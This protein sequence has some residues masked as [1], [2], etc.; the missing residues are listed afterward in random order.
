[1]RENAKVSNEIQKIRDQ[2]HSGI[3]RLQQV[4]SAFPVINRVQTVSIDDYESVKKM[5]E[6]T[7]R[8]I[9]PPK[10]ADGHELDRKEWIKG[11]IEKIE[12][13]SNLLVSSEQHKVS[14]GMDMVARILPFLLIGG[15]SQTEV[16]AYLKAK[17]EAA[18]SVLGEL[19]STQE[20]E[21]TLVDTKTRHEEKPKE[22]SMQ[23]EVDDS[24]DL[25]ANDAV[26]DP[27]EIKEKPSVEQEGDKT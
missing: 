14:E 5:W 26:K 13:V 10:S 3:P 7:Y 9:S 18:K 24:K 17:E 16:V 6:D 21:D 2:G 19:A 8:K 25:P 12:A 20:E 15:F 11:D 1:M 23:E 22:L 27:Q 4:H